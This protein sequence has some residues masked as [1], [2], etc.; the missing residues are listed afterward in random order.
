VSNPEAH[1]SED[2]S[3]ARWM[4]TAIRFGIVLLMAALCLQILVPFVVPVAWGIIIAVALRPVHVWLGDALGGRARTSAGLL[5]VVLLVLVI[6][7]AGFFA[8]SIVD[9]AGTLAKH[10]S[11]ESFKFP[12]PPAAVRDWPLIGEPIYSFWSQAKANLGGTLKQ[13]SSEI[14]A[15]GGWLLSTSA[16]TGLAILQF[17][18]SIIVAGV[19]LAS[20]D[21]GQRVANAISI[22]VAGTEGEGYVEMAASTVRSVCVGIIGVAVIQA[23]LISVGF[24]VAG[25]PHAGLWAALCLFL[26]ILQLTPMLVVVPI[27]FYVFSTESTAVAVVFTIWELLAGASDNVL[28]PILLGRGAHVP[29]LVIFLGSIGGFISYGF[30]GLF[31]GAVVL[32]LGY[33]LFMAWL[34]LAATVGGPEASAP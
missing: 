24:L 11:A 16:G 14:A 20:A 19:L 8:G 13:F 34:G 4:E 1:G 32:S 9:S 30:I 27:V 5:T 29:M 26:A 22:R 17:L 7:P 25:V 15:V 31:V 28:K 18:V 21:A 3:F 2:D 12:P 23:A 33:E 6:A 10:L